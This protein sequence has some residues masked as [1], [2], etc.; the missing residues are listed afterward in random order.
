MCK[1]DSSRNITRA[2]QRKDSQ[3]DPT[4]Q[5]RLVVGLLGHASLVYTGGVSAILMSFQ[6]V[7]KQHFNYCCSTA[8]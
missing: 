3:E 8:F 2:D 5:I 4:W 1:E 6:R 7:E